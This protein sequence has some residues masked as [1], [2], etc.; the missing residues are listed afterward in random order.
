MSLPSPDERL[1]GLVRRWVEGGQGGARPPIIGVSGAQGSGK[2][3]LCR[4]LAA[5][6]N[7][8]HFSIDDVY[9]TKAERARRAVTTHPLFATR[10]PPGTHD[11]ALAN[12]TITAL[13]Q[14]VGASHTPIPVF[15]KL[16]D[17][18]RPSTDWTV[19]AGRPNAI[20]IDG[21][22]LGATPIA[23]AE[24]VAPLNDLEAR[25]DPDGAWRRAWN[26]A[27]A[28]DY[29][30]WFGRFDAM[31]YLRNPSFDIVLDWRCEQE[32][33]ALRVLPEDLPRRRRA[34]LAYFVQHYERLTRHMMAGGVQAHATAVLDHRRRVQ[35]LQ[36]T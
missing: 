6:L 15:D 18:R 9:L 17:D 14:A 3:T 20:L 4:D 26:Q 13:T 35:S 19:F 34:E 36:I 22:C 1:T 28:G 7:L 11:L 12:A 31:L 25:A 5:R 32:A 29:R 23:E 10:G 16:A 33:S 24:L 27:L 8:A 21:W 2:T 30:R